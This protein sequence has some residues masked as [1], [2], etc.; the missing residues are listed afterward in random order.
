LWQRAEVG[1]VAVGNDKAFVNSVLD[2]ALDFV[3]GLCVAEVT[4][5]SV[6]L[7]DF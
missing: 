4:D 2:K 1:I 3:E 6:E 5:T 7:L